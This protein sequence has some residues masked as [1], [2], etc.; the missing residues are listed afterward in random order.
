MKQAILTGVKTIELQEVIERKL[1]EKDILVQLEVCGLCGSDLHIFEGHHPVIGPPVVMGHE[2]SGR[3]IQCGTEV[4]G[5]KVGDY[6]A[7][8]PAIGCGRCEHCLQGK[9][10]LCEDLQ[11][12]GGHVPGA[13]AESI[14]VPEDNLVKIPEQFTATEGAMVESVAV[15]VHAVSHFSKIKG[16]TFA[17]LGAGPIG[18]LTFQVL[19]AFGAKRIFVSDPNETRRVLA[20]TLGA[21]IVI[22]PVH[23]NLLKIAFEKNNSQKLD[24]AVDCAGLEMT[25]QQALTIT[26]NGG[27]IVI[28]AIFGKNPTIPMRLL[29]REERRLFGTQ[30]Y[31]KEDFETAIKLIQQQRIKVEALVTNRFDLD[32]IQDA[33]TLASSRASH[34]GKIMIHPQSL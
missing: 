15:A 5:F 7:G 19:K 26:K 23:E 6:V 22:D 21:D 8:I 2:F 28:S 24:G 14:V 27:E 12:I 20:E 9:F 11:V 32:H 4:K 34:V 31:R 30:M 25:L 16:Q 18:L 17:V 3:V 1:S 29:Q 10:N 13:F 33:F